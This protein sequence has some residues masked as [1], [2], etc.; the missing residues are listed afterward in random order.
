MRKF[1]KAILIYLF[2]ISPAWAAN[3]YVATTGSDSA[4]CSISE[5][6]LTIQHAV[7]LA[8][9]PDDSVLVND[10]IYTSGFNLVSHKGRAE[11]S[12]NI[13]NIT[14]AN[15]AVLTVANHGYSNGDLVFISGLDD[16]LT[17]GMVNLD[18]RW[19]TVANVTANTFELSGIDSSKFDRYVSGG[20]VQKVHPISV[21][22]INRGHVTIDKAKTV[23]GWSNLGQPP[24]TYTSSAMGDE[25]LFNLWKIGNT[26][27]L[28]QKSFVGQVTIEGDYYYDPVMH[29]F[30]IHT[31][32]DPNLSIYKQI[33]SSDIV[34][35]GSSWTLVD[36]FIAQ[37]ATIPI[38]TGYS[39]GFPTP[40]G[41]EALGPTNNNLVQYCTAQYAVMWGMAVTSASINF[42]SFTTYDFD[43]IQYVDERKGGQNG[44]CF[45][46]AANHNAD[47]GTYTTISDST[48]HDCRYHGIQSSN[49]W[50]N[51][52][53]HDNRIYNTSLVG[54]GSGTDIRCGYSGDNAKPMACRI[55]DNDLGG[56]A[57]GT[58][59]E[60]GCG[61]YFQDTDKDSKAWRNKIHDHD[62][63]GIYLFYAGTGPTG[64]D[65]ELI[66]N[67]LIWN[68]GTAGI[69]SDNNNSAYIYNNSF[70]NN[71]EKPIYGIGAGLSLNTNYAKNVYF[72]N[73]IVQTTTAASIVTKTNYSLTSDYNDL[74]RSSGFQVVWNNKKFDALGAYS[75]ASVYNWDSHSVIGD[76]LYAKPNLGDFRILSP[77][78]PAHSAGKDFLSTVPTD[79]AMTARHLPFDIGAY[80]VDDKT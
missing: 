54:S 19:F 58:G 64:P 60:K 49:A 56:G 68:N 38:L 34:V 32:S 23:T 69:R 10:G 27:L 51:Q 43:T 36:G 25:K 44:H 41:Q 40:S 62:W 20:M 63:H 77:K 79:Y 59:S 26:T 15:P 57:G 45:K 29:K 72:Y 53:F 70:Y 50:S 66:F 37:Y 78:T 31:T 67:N 8:I 16:Y 48:I 52:F 47:N 30:T 28:S 17:T 18:N 55:F 65:N 35:K 5:P 71:G 21:K 7:D 11:S 4:P 74:Y 46:N 3:Y 1:I 14:Q 22:A 9:N 75:A 33:S 80:K 73:N 42:T 24:N 6:C 61:I 76:P 2:L 12:Q 39:S 13:T